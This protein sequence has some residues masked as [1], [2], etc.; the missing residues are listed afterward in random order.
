MTEDY[1]PTWQS[2]MFVGL[3]GRRRACTLLDA[4]QLMASPEF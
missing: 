3:L 1:Q 4:A 2:R